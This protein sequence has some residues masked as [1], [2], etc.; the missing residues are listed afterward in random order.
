[1]ICASPPSWRR[2]RDP[3]PA[4]E[5]TRREGAQHG[6]TAQAPSSALLLTPSR[7]RRGD[8]TVRGHGGVGFQQAGR[9]LPTHSP[10]RGGPDCSSACPGRV[11]GTSAGKCCRDPAGPRAPESLRPRPSSPR[12]F[13][14][15]DLGQVCHGSDVWTTRRQLRSSLEN[16][17]LRNPQVRVVAVSSFTAGALFRGCAATVRLPPSRKTGSTPLP[18]SPGWTAQPALGCSW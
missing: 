18:A 10:P 13:G 6:P 17:L 2:C 16:R 5:A 14:L 12:A 1:M 9:G 4:T 7:S 3:M 8:R 15:R 11:Q